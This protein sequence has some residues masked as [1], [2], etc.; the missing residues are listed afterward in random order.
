MT[1]AYICDYVRTPI[2]RY[3]GALKDIRPDDLATIPLRVLKERHADVDWR[4]L[5]GWRR[6]WRAFPSASEAAP[7][8]ACAGRVSMPSARR[9]VRSARAMP[10]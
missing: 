3:A 10:I 7:S 6:C 5:D 8:T 9:R 1:Q 2:G 4:A